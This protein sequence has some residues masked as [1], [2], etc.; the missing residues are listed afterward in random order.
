METLE[1]KSLFWDVDVQ[2]LDVQK[3]RDFI[4]KRIFGMGDLEDLAWSRKEYGADV[5]KNL[6]LLSADGLDAKSRNFW[7]KYFHLSDEELCTPKRS[8]QGQSAFSTR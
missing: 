6:F 5:L 4:M 8:T 7:K 1:K 3:H 2:E